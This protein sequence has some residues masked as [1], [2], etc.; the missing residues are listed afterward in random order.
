M[1]TQ[2]NLS[3]TS[4]VPR[5]QAL[6]AVALAASGLLLPP[7]VNNA[8]ALSGWQ[9]CTIVGAAF[10]KLDLPYADNATDISKSADCSLLT[11]WC[12][13]Q[14]SIQIPRNSLAQFNACRMCVRRDTAGALLFF[15]TVSK[16]VVSHVAIAVGDGS[17]ISANSISSTGKPRVVLVQ[18]WANNFNWGPKF[19][20]AA[21]PF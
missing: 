2:F 16:T 7:F 3:L 17:M 20:T 21:V 6:K 12:Y 1:T 9:A 18:N 19:V 8:H 15:R 4:S 14:A 13:K 5:R 10:K 11:Q